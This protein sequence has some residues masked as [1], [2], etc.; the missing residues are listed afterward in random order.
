[1]EANSTSDSIMLAGKRILITQLGLGLAFVVYELFSNGAIGVESALTGVVIAIVPSMIGMMFASMK[2]K[3]KPS[4]SLRD[5]MNLSRNIKLIYTIIMFVLTF[6]F[7]ALR[8]IVVLIAFC[9]TM[10]GHFL[11]P[12]FKDQDERKA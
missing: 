11:T 10:L 5:L 9:V 4:E 2:S 3:M 6:R 1:M 7:M 12:L 8:N